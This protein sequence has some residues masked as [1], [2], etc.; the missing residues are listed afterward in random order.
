MSASDHHEVNYIEAASG[1]KSWL[2]TLDH[3]R[4]GIMYLISVLIAFLAGGIFALLIRTELLTPGKTIMDAE[5]YNQV[6][7]L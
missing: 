4:I 1:L 3:K 5:Y 2:V 6:F 7:T